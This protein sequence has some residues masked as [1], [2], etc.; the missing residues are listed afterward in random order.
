M[1]LPTK[2]IPAHEAL[3]GAG[4]LILEKTSRPVALSRLWED[5][6]TNSS[7]QTYERFV[8]TLYML[9]IIGVIEI[10]GVMIIRAKNDSRNLF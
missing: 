9:H 6:K 7:I 5:V 2:H 10:K 8:L 4:A 3:I 1:I